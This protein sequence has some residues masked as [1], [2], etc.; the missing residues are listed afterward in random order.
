MSN[1]INTYLK[2]QKCTFSEYQNS[3][4][5]ANTI[6][7]VIDKLRVFI[8]EK[9]YFQ[10][11]TIEQFEETLKTYSITEK[12][13]N[14][15][16]EQKLSN[17][18]INSVITTE[19]LEWIDKPEPQDKDYVVITHKYSNTNRVQL[20]ITID[21]TNHNSIIYS[22]VIYVKDDVDVIS[23]WSN[24]Y[25]MWK[26]QL[27]EIQTDINN[28]EN[29]INNIED[30]IT[31]LQKESF[32][33]VGWISNNDYEISTLPANS[34]AYAQSSDSQS[35]FN[36]A[37]AIITAK[38]TT[39]W[40]MQFA[41]STNSTAIKTRI[42]NINEPATVFYNGANKTADAS[43]NY[44]WIDS[45]HK[46]IDIDKINISSAKGSL[47]DKQ[48]GETI[49][50]SRWN[51]V[52]TLKG[53]LEALNYE[54]GTFGGNSAMWGDNTTGKIY[55]TYQIW[56]DYCTIS[57]VAE[58]APASWS[59]NGNIQQTAIYSLPIPVASDN[60]SSGISTGDGGT[61]A[62]ILNDYTYGDDGYDNSEK[63]Y[64]LFSDAYIISTGS[65]FSTTDNK[66]ID[67]LVIRLRG[68][69]KMSGRKVKFTLTYKCR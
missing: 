26:D 50:G 47:I 22:R 54:T 32:N 25:L 9:E 52:T 30:D 34:I 67:V 29:D 7:F 48:T 66:A 60:N 69:S 35:P 49:S 59:Q 33:Y 3:L 18:N 44:G 28:I 20:A 15:D 37:S 56:G 5:D 14:E 36:G 58:E 63:Y 55:G 6:Y 42:V 24:E 4:K 17:I 27:N 40:K 53:A 61:S 13:F 11:A 43:N 39:N 45:I 10:S 62:M 8:G 2:I 41:I 57:A 51:N 38:Y 46:N 19:N 68:N 31:Q 65:I 12:Q 1:I 21:D 16:Y 23:N 64:N